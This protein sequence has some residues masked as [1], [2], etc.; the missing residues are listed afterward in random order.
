MLIDIHAHAYR[1]KPPVV[2]FCTCEELLHEQERLGIDKTV[3]SAAANNKITHEN[4]MR[5]L[6]L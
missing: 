6:G 5:L 4:A 3:I 2:P 1:Y